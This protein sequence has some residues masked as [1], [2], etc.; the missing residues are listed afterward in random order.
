MCDENKN[1]AHNT[2]EMVKMISLD[3]TYMLFHHVRTSLH[4]LFQMILP[5][6]PF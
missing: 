4:H 6:L 3:H 5:S 1:V 2:A